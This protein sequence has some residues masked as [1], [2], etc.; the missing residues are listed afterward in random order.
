MKKID[1]VYLR[2]LFF[3]TLGN[4]L[5]IGSLLVVGKTFAPVVWQEAVYLLRTVKKVE[6]VVV[7]AESK[8]PASNK[9]RGNAFASLLSKFTETKEVIVPKDP[10]YSI[11]IPKIAANSRVI[12]NVNSANYEEYIDALKYGVAHAL[13]TA[14]PGE[15]GHIYLFAHSTDT[16]LN[17]D[18][19]NAVFYLLYKLDPG[20]S[21]YLFYK[22]KKHIYKVLGKKVVD[23]SEVFYLTRSATSEFLTLQTCWPPGTTLQRMLIFAVPI[24]E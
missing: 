9:A 3:R 15:N 5:I 16:L 21:I 20:D 1:N 14:Y 6:T 13:G 18:S 10:E 23:P 7:S 8:E 11:V 12:K 22:G 4:L 24:S 19:Y 2:L 17:V